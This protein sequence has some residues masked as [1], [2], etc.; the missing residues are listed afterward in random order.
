MAVK[1]NSSIDNQ[2]KKAVR[3]FNNKVTRL[4]KSDRELIIPE[5]ESITAIKD[6]VKTKWDLK[7]ELDRLERY[8]A[9]GMEDTIVTSEG[10]KLSKFDYLTI[11]KEQRRLSQRLNRELERYGEITPE[12]LGKKQAGSYFRMG[13]Q[14]V[15]VLENKIARLK[16]KNLRKVTPEQLKSLTSLI[17]KLNANYRKDPSTFYENFIEGSLLN[18]NEFIGKDREK[19]EYIQNKLKEL[20]PEQFLKAWNTEQGLKDMQDFYIAS[21]EVGVT[22]SDLEEDVNMKIDA[23]YENIDVIVEHYK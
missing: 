19:I 2:L 18:L 4:E 17:N 6:R 5:K 15:G 1:Y 9:R 22:P 21:H 8:T 16:D 7:R 3:N 23:L 11:Q 14:K 13:D 10:A 20:T 12:V